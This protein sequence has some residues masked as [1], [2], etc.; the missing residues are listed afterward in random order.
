MYVILVLCMEFIISLFDCTMQY[1]HVG[2]IFWFYAR[3]ICRIRACLITESQSI[4]HGLA[5]KE[6]LNFVQIGIGRQ[7]R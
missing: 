5:V 1:A 6:S 3:G 7:S 2:T 4:N